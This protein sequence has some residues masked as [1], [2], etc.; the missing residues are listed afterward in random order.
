MTVSVILKGMIDKQGFQPIQIRVADGKARS[1]IPTGLKVLPKDF[2]NGKVKPSCPT[3]KLYNDIITRKIYLLQAEIAEGKFRTEKKET[4]LYKFIDESM[5]QWTRRKAPETIRQHHS[6]I[7]K[8]R[9]FRSSVNLS[10]VSAAWLNDYTE[11]LYSIGNTTNT[12]HKSLKFLKMAI[13]K[14]HREKLIPDNPFGIFEGPKYK[15]PKRIFLTPDQVRAVDKFCQDKKCPQELRF[16]G[17]WF[18]VACYTGLRFS[19]LA[20]FSKKNIHSGRLI[21]YTQKTGQPISQP[22][23]KTILK[24]FDRVNYKPMAVTNYHAN[25]LLHAI[26]DALE[27]ERFSFHTAR[28]TFATMALSAGTR[29]EVVGKMLGHSNLRTTAIYAKLIDPVIDEEFKKFRK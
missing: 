15:D 11:H 6:E 17:T 3:H 4:S 5:P 12:V 26:T 21:I 2:A 8:L 23:D 14:A 19:D 25:R 22:L 13:L 29:I 20:K 24:L 10:Q 1:F 28:H 18:V 16:I 27:M 7:N 9:R